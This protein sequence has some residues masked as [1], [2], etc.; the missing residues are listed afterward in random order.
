MAILE[1]DQRN[2]QWVTTEP[3]P[4]LVNRDTV[5]P[6]T[7]DNGA[8]WVLVGTG[9]FLNNGDLRSNETTHTIYAIKDGGEKKT[10]DFENKTRSDWT[11]ITG[12]N[13]S[14]RLDA[15]AE[16]WYEDMANGYHVN[17]R[18]VTSF[19]MMV[20]GANKYIGA[21][22]SG[23][24]DMVDLCDSAAFEGRLFSRYIESGAT[25]LSGK[26]FNAITGGITDIA[27]V[28]TADGKIKFMASKA[29]G[30]GAELSPDEPDQPKVAAPDEPPEDV[31]RYSVRYIAP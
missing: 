16:G 1:D 18:P 26:H 13:V 17:V 21:L 27:V 6:A 11:A 12:A 23:E 28:K 20:Y 25:A 7:G 2:K 19:G 5:D 8:R 10:S 22:P 31:Q 29:N 4:Q 15:D 24:G 30:S 9:G 14:G 3:W